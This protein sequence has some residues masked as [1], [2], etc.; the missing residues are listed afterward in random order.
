MWAWVV[1]SADE[2]MC[3]DDEKH[4]IIHET[5]H[6]QR[7]FSFFPLVEMKESRKKEI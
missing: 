3:D 6:S 2:M 1:Y 5:F 7:T 4:K